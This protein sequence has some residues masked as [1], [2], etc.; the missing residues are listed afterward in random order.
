MNNHSSEL[1]SESPGNWAPQTFGV[2]FDVWGFQ[3]FW[4]PVAGPDENESEIPECLQENGLELTDLMESACR[5]GGNPKA[6]V[7]RDNRVLLIIPDVLP[8]KLKMAA[9]GI[10]PKGQDA[11]LTEKLAASTQ[12][13]RRQHQQL[14]EQQQELNSY[15]YQV[16]QDFEELTWLRNLTEFLDFCDIT[17]PLE[18]VAER[19]VPALREIIGAQALVLIIA[20][21]ANDPEQQQSSLGVP[22]VWSGDQL[23]DSE[24]TVSLVEL[25]WDSESTQPLVRNHIHQ[26]PDFAKFSNIESCILVPVAKKS[27]GCT[28]GWLLALNR[29][30]SI[31]IGAPLEDEDRQFCPGEDEFGTVEASLLSSASIMLATHARN[32]GLLQEKEKLLIGVIRAL[33]NAMDAKDS[34]TCGHSDRVALISKRIGEELKLEHQE[35]DRLYM[36]GLLHDIGKIGIPDDVLLKRDRL[37]EKEFDEIKN[38]PVIGHEILRHLEQLKY[39]LPGVLHHHESVDG[40]GYPDGLMGDEIPLA[41]RVL[42]IADS[43]DAMTSTRPYRKAMPLEKAEQILRD[44]AGTQWDAGVIEAFFLALDD[45]LLIGECSEGHTQAL[46]EGGQGSNENDSDSII[47]AVAASDGGNSD[48]RASDRRKTERREE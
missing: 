2:P 10:L 20:N 14:V 38:H 27:S 3:E 29:E 39:V 21:D 19:T 42:A 47:S 32:I 44:G 11:E 41:A 48:R 25:M 30:P 24:A 43:F 6:M 9:V 40:R 15:A 31:A 28:V 4:Q 18:E 37:S 22:L 7:L 17:N 36:T 45:I 1:N 35:C 8:A 26:N 5:N 13:N 16:S 34:Y 12:L 23:L 46:L 33:I